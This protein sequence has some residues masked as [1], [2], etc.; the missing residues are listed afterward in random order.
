[1]RPLEQLLLIFCFLEVLI[2]FSLIKSLPQKVTDV[3]RAL[4]IQSEISP[5]LCAFHIVS[6]HNHTNEMSALLTK[7]MKQ[8]D[9]QD[10]RSMAVQ[11]H[12]RA[13]S[14]LWNS[15]SKLTQTPKPQVSYRYFHPSKT[16][17][18][19]TM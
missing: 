1:M 9:Q 5:R 16:G 13:Y 18:S 15:N 7:N 10:G 19:I 2:F 4:A 17:I 14:V 3:V 12:H 6:L 11:Y 8:I